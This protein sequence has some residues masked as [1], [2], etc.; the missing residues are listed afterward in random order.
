MLLLLSVL[1]LKKKNVSAACDCITFIPRFV[2]IGHL[3][4]DVEIEGRQPSLTIGIVSVTT[5]VL[6]RETLQFSYEKEYG[7]QNQDSFLSI[8]TL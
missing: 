6:D 7:N 2:K 4:Q 3:V 1:K 5:F 8:Y